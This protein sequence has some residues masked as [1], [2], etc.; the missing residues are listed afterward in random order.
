MKIG[1]YGTGGTGREVYEIIQDIYELKGKLYEEIIFIDDITEDKEL[2]GCRIL[3]F[4][5]VINEGIKDIRVA[6]AVG[7]PN[8]RA[9]LREKVEAKGYSLISVI[10][11]RANVSRFAVIEDGVIIKGNCFVSNKAVVKKNVLLQ[12][13]AVV[14][15]DVVI[16]EDSLISNF[17]CIGGFSNI[18]DRVYIAMHSAIIDRINIG[19][20]CIIGLSTSVF[21]DVEEGKIV[22]GNPGRIISNN[23]NKKV[24][25]Y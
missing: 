2:F 21:K 14:G 5:E 22:L 25:K 16:N 3:S 20:D 24:F 19:N 4:D 8:L 9:K 23:N 6:I 10:H 15:H 1:I 13:Y 7:E 18:G 11:P 17:V 12:A